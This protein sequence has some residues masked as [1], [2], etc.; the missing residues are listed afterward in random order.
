M[1]TKIVFWLGLVFVLSLLMA[2]CS[3]TSPTPQSEDTKSVESVVTEEPTAESVAT[4][5]PIAESVVAEEPTAESV[6]AEEP[7]AE[8]VA[9]EEPT[10]ESVVTEEPETTG[11]RTGDIAP[12]FTLPDSNGNMVRLADELNDNRMVVLVFYASYY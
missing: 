1:K 11:P 8:S 3:G 12:D 6:V 2:A 4:K 9:T 5:E 10:A 7:T